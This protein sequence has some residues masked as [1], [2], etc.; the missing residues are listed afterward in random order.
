MTAD[1]MLSMLQTA[2]SDLADAESRYAAIRAHERDTHP[3]LPLAVADIRA[4]GRRD[5]Q[6]AMRDWS[7]A[8]TRIQSYGAAA[9]ALLLAES[10]R[11]TLA[12]RSDVDERDLKPILPPGLAY[13]GF[14][15]NGR[16]S[17]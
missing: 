1:E 17:G 5:M 7:T 3:Q 9:T 13:D 4:D 15:V 12:R 2:L 11:R 8:H 10:R 14:A 6:Q 16:R